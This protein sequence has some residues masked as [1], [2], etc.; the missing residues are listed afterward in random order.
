MYFQP[1]NKSFID[2]VV[3]RENAIA[4]THFTPVSLPF[5]TQTQQLIREGL[6]RNTAFDDKTKNI[7]QL[8]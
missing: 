5:F 8:N 6:M 4:E 3:H 1:L 2:G 7:K